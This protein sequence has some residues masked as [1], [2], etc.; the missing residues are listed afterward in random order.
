MCFF[1]VQCSLAAFPVDSDVLNYL[2]KPGFVVLRK[3]SNDVIRFL[4]LFLNPK[5]KSIIP[6][7]PSTRRDVRSHGC[8]FIGFLKTPRLLGDDCRIVDVPNCDNAYANR[9]KK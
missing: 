7:A 5:Y 3:S 8:K 4:A 1:M 9:A 2:K 6:L